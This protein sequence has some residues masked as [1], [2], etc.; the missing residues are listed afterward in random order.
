MTCPS[1][2]PGPSPASGRGATTKWWVRVVT[3]GLKSLCENSFLLSF[4][5]VRQP[6]DDEES[7]TA[8]KTFRARFLPLSAL[9]V[10]M[11][12]ERKFSHRLCRPSG[13]MNINAACSPTAYAVGYSLAPLRGSR[14]F[15]A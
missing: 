8:L 11:T 14:V 4:R 13:A 1:P 15:T 9:G 12:V 6:T 3:A 2:S 5:G 7:R 10:G